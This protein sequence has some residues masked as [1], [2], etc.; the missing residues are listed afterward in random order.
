MPP[1]HAGGA[2]GGRAVRGQQLAP[3]WHE[4]KTAHVLS[5]KAGWGREEKVEGFVRQVYASELLGGG[6]SNFA[7]YTQLPTASIYNHQK[8]GKF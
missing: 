3:Q 1:S 2:V 4:W 5:H 7:S 8:Y 6:Q